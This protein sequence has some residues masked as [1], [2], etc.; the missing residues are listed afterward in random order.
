M[1]TS[2]S[3]LFLV[4][5]GWT[6]TTLVTNGDYKDAIKDE[7]ANMLEIIKMLGVSIKGLIQILIKAS[8]SPK[9]VDSIEEVKDNIV[10]ITENEANEVE[11]TKAA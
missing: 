2:L 3:L 4:L 8:F 7:L 6:I 10:S 11:E 5:V 1:I 9:T